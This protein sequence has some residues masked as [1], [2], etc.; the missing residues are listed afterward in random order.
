MK[1][2]NVKKIT[3]LGKKGTLLLLDTSLIHRGSPLRMSERYALT[4]YLYPSRQV[5]MY[6][7]HF[8]PRLK[9]D[10]HFNKSNS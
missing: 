5:P 10:L 1:K 4:N 7:N 8:Q 6:E 2:K 3:L 9:N